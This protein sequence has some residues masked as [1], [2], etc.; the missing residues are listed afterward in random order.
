MHP[1]IPPHQRPRRSDTLAILDMRMFVAVWP[2]DPTLKRLKMLELGPVQ[3]LR[4]VRPGRWHITL[5]FLGEVED[6]LVPALVDALRDA[7]EAWRARSDARSAPER[8]GSAANGC[9]RFPPPVSMKGP[10]RYAGRPC[11]LSRTPTTV[12]RRSPGT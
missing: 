9:S 6:D 7:A 12:K 1:P 10:R 2:D 11:L 4:L 8:H 3:G 5:R